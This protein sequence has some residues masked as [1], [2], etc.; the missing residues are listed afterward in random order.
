MTASSRPFVLEA[1]VENLQQGLLAEKNHA[2]RIE[3]CQRLDIGG[4]TPDYDLIRAAVNKIKIPVK[5]MIRPRGGDFIY[6]ESEINRMKSDIKYCKSIG[7]GEVVF[8]AL[9]ENGEVDNNLTKILARHAFPMKVTF[10]KAI[11]EVNNYMK[12]LTN[13]SFIKNINGVLTSGTK[14]NAL[15]GKD[16]IRKAA[17]EFSGTL[18]IIA[19]GSITNTNLKKIHSELD[20]KE[21]HGKKIV[22]DL[23]SKEYYK[24]R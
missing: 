12:S 22:G 14:E 3:L 21:Y 6:S 5:I 11:D 9:T 23:I 2:D 18:N 4:V 16:Y 13:L 17:K 19:A 20:I 1:C 15:A 24:R 8:G 10:H 7:V